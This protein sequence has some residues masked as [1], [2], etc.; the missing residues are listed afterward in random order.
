M[1]LAPEAARGD[2]ESERKHAVPAAKESPAQD[3]GPHPLGGVFS[4]LGADG[5]DTTDSRRVSGP[6]LQRRA[7]GEMRTL[8]M[9][10]LQQGAGNQK[11][12][13]F[14][15]QL[16]RSSVI[17]R[18]CACGGTCTSCQEKKEKGGEEEESKILQRQASTAGDRGGTVDADV[19]PTDS[20]GQPLDHSA[21][22]FMEPRFGSDFSDVRVH[23]DSRAAQSA[24]ALA[25][26]AYTTGRDIYFAAG[27]YAPSSRDGQHLLAHELTHTLQQ[28]KA[29]AALTTRAGGVLVADASDPLEAEAQHAASSI[30]GE[31]GAI[32][33]IS[34]NVAPAVRREST[35]DVIVN[36]AESAGEAIVGTA[37]DAGQFVAD[38]AKD[39]ARGAQVVGHAVADEARSVAKEAAVV[40]HAVADEAKALASG[41][42]SAIESGAQAVAH[43]AEE[44]GDW[45]ATEAGSVAK[46]LAR[47][48][49]GVLTLTSGGLEIILPKVCPIPAIPITFKLPSIDKEIMFPIGALPLGPV[50]LVAE[51][52]IAGHLQPTVQ[53]QLGPICLEGR[54]LIN[55]VTNTYAIRGSVSATAAASLAAEVRA[56]LRASASIAGV[57]VV[58]G[59]PIPIEIPAVGLEGGLAGLLRVIGA[60]TLTFGK[61]L[62]IARGTISM[63]ESTQLALGLAGDMFLGAYAQLDV[64]G[65]NLCRIYWQPFE[66]HGDVGASLGVSIGLAVV[67]GAPPRIVPR[68]TPPTLTRIPFEQIPLLLSRKGF[69]DDCDFLDRTCTLLRKLHLLPSQNGGSWSW[70]GP[71]GP[72]TRLPG[73]LAAYEKNPH[74]TSGAQC[75]GACGPN[76]ETC[77]GSP[78][79]TYTDPVSGD[80]WLY[81]NFQDC[82]S[83][84]GCREH[85]AA[86]DWA[87]HVHGETGKRAVVMPWHMAANIECAC[88]NLA[89]NCIAWIFGLPPYDSKIYFA[90]TA[91]LVKRGGGGGKSF[92]AGSCRADYPSAPL[93]VASYIDRDA[94]LV[95]WGSQN[96]IGSFRDCRIDS[97]LPGGIF[98][99]KGGPG[100]LWHCRATDAVTGQ[101]VTVSIIECICCRPDDTSGAEWLQPQIVVEPGMSEELILELCERNLIERM[102]CIPVEQDM[103]ARFGN[104]RRNLNL[105]PDRDPKAKLRSDDAPL[106]AT[107]KQQYNKLDSWNIFIHAN[108]PDL[109]AEFESRFQLEKQRIVWIEELKQLT[110]LYKESFRDLK[111]TDTDAYQALY[112]FEVGE[113]MQGKIDKMVHDIASWYKIKTGSPESESD[114]IEE[115]HK[116]GTELWRAA[117]RRAILQVNRVLSRL[118]P[119]AKTSILVWLGRERAKNPGV[120]L[121]G[122]V[123]DLDYIGSLSTGYKGPPKQQIRFDP[124]NFDVDANLKAPPLAKWALA[125]DP[126]HPRP[127]RQRIFGRT[128]SIDPLNNFSDQAHAELVA[129][130]QGYKTSEKFDV[131]LAAEDLPEQKREQGLTERLYKL[132]DDL[133]EDDY[134][135]MLG[136]LDRGGYLKKGGNAVRGDL[137]EAEFKAASAIMDRYEP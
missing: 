69:K 89:G 93:C 114:I 106:I 22:E 34:S 123:G 90:D 39:V 63:D 23:T 117:W 107:F 7:N 56:G 104:R 59:L 30:L 130:A 79:Y 122:P 120:N 85:D 31:G 61:T 5:S 82:N 111:N 48:L 40:G 2:F 37:E 4:A 11:A 41:T 55:P 75:R 135:E 6:L 60:G 101:D 49:G 8:V 121:S 125:L 57:V 28:A 112:E 119:P 134:R 62:S 17:Q 50:E 98:A 96:K 108:H 36:G 29:P 99:C 15:T 133:D 27:K 19:I 46:A 67:P 3:R 97:G 76:C 66:W 65:D 25:A 12:Q 42:R 72:G 129:R 102:I 10:R 118:W 68:I 88:N 100:N 77:K 1:P 110:K 18:A 54:I 127:D 116:E 43:E 20:P 105:D 26:D 9:R 126:K 131:A 64:A 32:P 83:N 14:V 86:Y 128:T 71:Y 109:V 132:R 113:V 70:T 44:V 103:I 137:S 74:I 84:A 94:T 16:R 52:G 136:E 21:R 53:I 91:S 95:R 81:T 92:T 47:S 124:D 24:N 33:S 51:V 13:Q 35:W 115:V 78:S 73:P 87:A 38:E 80:V 45:L 58:G